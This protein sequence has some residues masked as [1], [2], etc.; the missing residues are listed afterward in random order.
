MSYTKKWLP[1]NIMVPDNVSIWKEVAADIHNHMIL[2]GLEATADTGQIDISSVSAMPADSTYAGFKMY[3][4]TDTTLPDIYIKLKFGAFAD[5]TNSSAD[6]N[7]AGYLRI[8]VTIGIGTD[9][10]GN[11]TG[12]TI[13]YGCPQTYSGGASRFGSPYASS[14]S[15]F[16][17]ICLNKPRGFFG[18]YYQTHGRWGGISGYLNT[19]RGASLAIN[20]QRCYNTDGTLSNDGLAVLYPNLTVANNSDYIGGST[21]QS[22][23]KY[24][25]YDGSSVT[26]GLNQISSCITNPSQNSLVL[27]HPFVYKPDGKI[28]VMNC[29]AI[30]PMNSALPGQEVS[31]EYK[32]TV[33]QNMICVGQETNMSYFPTSGQ[34]S[35]TFILYE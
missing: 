21:Q 17:M 13:E 5:G 20:I 33:N 8:L 26:A 35:N 30:G 19:T 28:I 10:A 4:W 9:G 29:V 14:S 1:A 32:P 18:F 2:A 23:T 15:G 31:L 24:L 34:Q 25:S 16:N 12:S 11:F 22:Q 6:Y 3:K 7:R 27:Q